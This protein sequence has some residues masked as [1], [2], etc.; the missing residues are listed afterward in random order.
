MRHLWLFALIVGVALTRP[1]AAQ[2][3][4]TKAAELRQKLVA[5]LEKTATGLDGVMGYAIVDLTSGDRVERLPSAV[6]ATAST[7]KLAIL[8]EL[9][10][11]AD[12]GKLSLDTVRPLD[13]QQVVGGTG[14]L[15]ELTAPAMPLRDYATLMVVLSD[16]TATNVLVDVVGMTNVTARMA[17]L[18]LKDTKLRRKM[19]DL[20]AAHRGDENVSTPSEIARLL[21]ILYRGEG[22]KKES[23]EALLAIL[24]KSKTTPMR[25][26]IP[27]GVAVANKPGTLEGVEVDAGIVYLQG[28]PYVL[29]VMTTY[30]T[31]NA[32]GEA[33]ITS[34]SQAA[35]EYFN[36]LAKSSEYGRSIR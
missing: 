17:S 6:F 3:T 5:S 12:E 22:L 29:S 28:R 1:V 25:R 8:Y 18:G 4:D 32:A 7:I 11:Q 9:F 34:A 27:P 24:K 13:R 33:A 19:I 20:A 15:A 31:Q 10:K 14:V 16:N 30:L 23:Q 26:G 21:E 35:F 36:R 2:P